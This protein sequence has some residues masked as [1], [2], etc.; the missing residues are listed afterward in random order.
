MKRES[1]VWSGCREYHV[2]VITNYDATLIHEA[3]E[4]ETA[5]RRE[6]A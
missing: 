3:S 4:T 5:G 6:I 2:G 1:K